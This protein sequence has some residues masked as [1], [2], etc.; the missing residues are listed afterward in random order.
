MHWYLVGQRPSEI[1]STLLPQFVL[2][3]LEGIVPSDSS[4]SWL[5]LE[6]QL[7]T[8]AW[9][10]YGFSEEMRTGRTCFAYL[11]PWN[12]H[13][14]SKNGYEFQSKMALNATVSVF[15]KFVSK[16]CSQRE[17]PFIFWMDCSSGSSYLQYDHLA[18]AISSDSLR[19][20]VQC[21]VILHYNILKTPGYSIH[22]FTPA[23]LANE[24]LNEKRDVVM[25]LIRV[26]VAWRWIVIDIAFWIRNVFVVHS[27]S[28][29]GHDTKFHTF[30]SLNHIQAVTTRKSEVWW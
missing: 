20:T 22:I 8:S 26:A 30:V 9:C 17:I 11:N 14:K 5:T 6:W 29:T 16:F 7:V 27:K 1:H 3:S 12:L 25:Q 23:G 2:P 24:Y 18:N 19:D 21:H 13:S 28:S 4:S 10:D 15:P